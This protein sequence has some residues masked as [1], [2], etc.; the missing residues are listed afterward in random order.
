MHT[1]KVTWAGLTTY[2]VHNLAA[3]QKPS[4][5]VVL[6]HGYGAPGTD[7]V[8]LA[9]PLL[10]MGADYAN[11]IVLIFPSAPLDLAKSGLPGGRAWWPVDLDR[12]INRRTPELLDQFRRAR[13]AGLIE[14]R[15]KLIGLL[16][17]AGKQ[18]GLT[19]D[20]FVLGGFSQGAILTT[21]VALR[22]KKA[23][24]GLCILSGALTNE[25]QWRPLASERGPLT[26][27]QSHGQHDSILPFPMATALRDLLLESG[28]DLDFLPFDGDHEIPLEVLHR[29]AHFIQSLAS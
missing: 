7:L 20:R 21:D 1:E 9:Q 17:E 5:A 4:L 10:S 22:L 25:A 28:A 6:C 24:A 11:K 29:L 13:P 27:L 8:G 2:V 15:D 16:S 3:G 19:A 26:V 18:F 23:P 12:L 14:S